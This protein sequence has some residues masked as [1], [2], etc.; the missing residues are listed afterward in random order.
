MRILI[1]AGIGLSVILSLKADS[2]INNKIS[3]ENAIRRDHSLVV[4]GR[5][6]EKCLLLMDSAKLIEEWRNKKSKITKRVS[7]GDLFSDVFGVKSEKH[8]LYDYLIYYV[9]DKVVCAIY[10]DRLCAVIGFVNKRITVDAVDIEKGIDN[11]ILNYGNESLEIL[12]CSNS[13]F[14]VYPKLGIAVADDNGDD[15]IDLYIVFIK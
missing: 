7:N 3:I 2:S 15:S 12:R 8:I 14:Y 9:E 11:F 5:G 6:A 13:K 1:V 10:R 4:P